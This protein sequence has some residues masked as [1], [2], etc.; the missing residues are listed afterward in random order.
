MTNRI[1]FTG[2]GGA[3]NEAIW[4]LL[5]HKYELY[6]ADACIE[7]IDHAIPEERRL[8][9]PFANQDDFVHKIK[10]I[11]SENNIDIIVPG[12]DEELIPLCKNRAEFGSE[13][14]APPLEFV[15]LMLNK[16]DCAN[17]IIAAGLRAPKTVPISDINELDLPFILKPR[18]GRGSRGVSIIKSERGIDAYKLLHNSD[19]SEIIGQE[20][21]VGDEYTILVAGDM[22]GRLVASIPV[23]IDIK[24]GITISAKTELNLTINDY[25]KNFH[26]AFKPTGVYN[27]Q[28]ILTKGGVVLPFEVNPRIS[29]TFCLGIASGF[30][31]FSDMSTLSK[32]KAIFTPE[33]EFNIRRSWYNNIWETK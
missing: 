1:L 5:S 33:R 15:E 21:C 10:K 8:L 9:I 13:I 18:S 29:T 22:E 17:S 28:C 25:V 4:R 12:V 14:F 23:K 6:F 2:G 19:S 31:P 30:D 16:L 11:S 24:K 26:N 20:L 3:G 7:S 32:N 27:I